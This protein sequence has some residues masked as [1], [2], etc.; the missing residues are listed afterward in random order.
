MTKTTTAALVLAAIAGGVALY[1]QDPPVC[2]EGE[3]YM[4]VVAVRHEDD[5]CT[6]VPIWLTCGTPPTLVN[7]VDSEEVPIP[8]G[9]L[10]PG[11]VR[12][13]SIAEA[14]P[15][16]MVGYVGRHATAEGEMHTPEEPPHW[17]ICQGEGCYAAGDV[18]HIPIGGPD[19][20]WCQRLKRMYPE[21]DC[22]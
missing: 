9:D 2:S 11:E 21:V 1:Q 14:Y 6:R 5:T 17:G 12:S 13:V 4:P 7:T 15:L 19:G 8:C 20:Y 22:P 16:S 18:E 10:A 3:T